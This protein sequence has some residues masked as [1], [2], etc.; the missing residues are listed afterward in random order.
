MKSSGE[1]DSYQTFY[2]GGVNIFVDVS[3]FFISPLQ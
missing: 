2:F 1:L 3:S